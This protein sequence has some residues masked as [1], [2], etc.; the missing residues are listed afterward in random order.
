MIEKKTHSDFSHLLDFAQSLNKQTDYVEILRIVVF[1]VCELLEA[2]NALIMMINPGTQETIKTVLSHDGK[3]MDFAQ[4][5]ITGWMMQEHHSL[6]TDD[7]TED[8]RFKKLPRKEL[9]GQSAIATLIKVEN[10]ILG[11][12]IVFKAKDSKPFLDE[13]LTLLENLAT[14]AAPYLRNLKK[15]KEYFLPEISENALIHKY[16]KMGLIGRSPKFLELLQ[17]IEAATRSD[18]RIILEGESGTGK[19]LI[20]RA[21]HQFSTRHDK[22]FVAIDCGTIP[23]HLIESELFGHKKGAFTGAFQDRKGLIE[24][25][26]GGTF[27]IDEIANLPME[28]Q[29]KIMRFLQE[30]EIRPL[31]S[32]ETKKV[33]VRIISASSR[34]LHKMVDEGCFRHDLYFRLHVYPIYVPA[35][36]EREQ[37]IPK[38]ANYFLNSYSKKYDKSIES[39]HPHLLHFLKKREWMGN[40]R[41]LQN[42]I[43]RLVTLSEQDDTILRI[44]ILPQ[45]L[46]DEWNHLSLTAPNGTHKSLKEHLLNFEAHVLRH[47]LE[48]NGWNQS[49]AARSL[50][51][52]EAI[53]RYRMKKLGIEREK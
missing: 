46:R 22:P 29:S 13:Q 8:S 9:R 50:D 6:I 43:E 14:I 41:E 32:N 20:A 15:I 17:A 34:S 3:T 5:Q 31:G 45:D 30:G 27:F 48:D 11:S 44:N 28:M 36:R 1:K 47:A 38:L 23:G 53:M 18:V 19:E 35:L 2:D 26:N 42:C 4:R 16:S 7:L 40:I 51:I 37:D 24:E 52:S 25:A 21:I 12:L 10:I 39:L 33:D 49:A